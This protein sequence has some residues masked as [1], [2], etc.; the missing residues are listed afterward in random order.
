M[1][2]TEREIEFDN[3]CNEL[4]GVLTD[5]Q[6]EIIQNYIHELKCT[7]DDLEYETADLQDEVDRLESE[8]TD[9]Q[10][11]IEEEK[12][13]QNATFRG[14]IQEIVDDQWKYIHLTYDTKEK[15][16]D[17]LDYILRYC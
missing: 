5:D 17:R 11:E 10:D 6:F 4:D 2:T 1:V 14:L 8:N 15:I 16:L 7:I 12:N 13:Y 9:L 3:L